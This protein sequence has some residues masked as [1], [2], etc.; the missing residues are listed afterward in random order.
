MNDLILYLDSRDALSVGL[1]SSADYAYCILVKVPLSAI[2]EISS[3][4]E[5][6]NDINTAI[7]RFLQEK[8][9]VS[10]ILTDVLFYR[11]ILSTAALFAI[12]GQ[13]DV[14][15]LLIKSTELI[16]NSMNR[17]EILSFLDNHE[18]S[19]VESVLEKIRNTAI[20]QD[21]M[22]SIRLVSRIKEIHAQLIGG[23]YGDLLQSFSRNA[24]N[25]IQFS[26][27]AQKS[28]ITSF[29]ADSKDVLT[30]NSQ[31]SISSYVREGV[32]SESD[33]TLFQSINQFCVS[34][35]TIFSE[36]F[37]EGREDD[38]LNEAYKNIWNFILRT[39]ALCFLPSKAYEK[40]R[41][42]LL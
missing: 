42:L 21:E 33:N 23:D 20:A 24:D 12:H 16:Y 10:L 36:I 37:V 25:V 5:A 2:N 3:K 30:C 27:M 19:S 32:V 39:K 8:D 29:I 6:D 9:S 4:E 13:P 7:Y 17:E 1:E 22:L 31:S 40:A 15:G 41:S 14:M 26:L 28:K 11:F 38:E 35:C 18:I 34:I